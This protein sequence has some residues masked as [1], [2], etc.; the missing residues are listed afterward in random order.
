[1]AFLGFSELIGL[2]GLL[3][4]VLF[5]PES[6]VYGG[7]EGFI[8]SIRSISKNR[9]VSRSLMETLFASIAVQGLYLY[10][11]S[12]LKEVYKTSTFSTGLIYSGTSVFFI[13]GVSLLVLL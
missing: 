3:L 8:D 13:M 2:I 6:H 1:M 9:G 10:C 7:Q 11:F 4:P 12:Y 5:L